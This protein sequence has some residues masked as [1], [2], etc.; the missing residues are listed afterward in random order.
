[1]KPNIQDRRDTISNSSPA[2]HFTMATAQKLK[3]KDEQK[4][5]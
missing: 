2:A 4:F 3:M 5:L 1:M